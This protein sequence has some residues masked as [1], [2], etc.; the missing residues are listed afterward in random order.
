MSE[1]IIAV[2]VGAVIGSLSS[3]VTALFLFDLSNRKRKKSIRAIA[4]AEVTAIMEKAQRYIDEQ[5]DR[6]ELSA[7]SP[8]LTSIASEIG[9]L[10][11][12][13]VIAFRRT[14]TL[15]M[16]MRKTGNKE[17]AQMAI[18]ACKEALNVIGK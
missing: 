14:V 16:E 12:K 10:S 18:S 1:Q 11:S 6:E 2:I 8:M 9:L 13:Q 3:L 4:A 7:S 15:D 17:K 5:S